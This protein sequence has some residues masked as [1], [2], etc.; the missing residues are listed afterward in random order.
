MLAAVPPDLLVQSGALEDRLLSGQGVD[1]SGD[2]GFRLALGRSAS[3]IYQ[4]IREIG[5]HDFSPVP[6]D[7]AYGSV[8]I[9]QRGLETAVKDRPDDLGAPHGGE[10]VFQQGYERVTVEHVHVFDLLHAVRRSDHIQVAEFFQ[11]AITG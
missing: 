5:D 8:E 3:R 4:Y 6:P 7:Q 10:L 11:S 2:Y 9:E 1:D